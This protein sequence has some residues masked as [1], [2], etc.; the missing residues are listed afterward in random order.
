MGGDRHLNLGKGDQ[1]GKE[2]RGL[3]DGLFQ[4]AATFGMTAEQIK[5]YKLQLA[6]ATPEQLRWASA[7]AATITGQ[8]EGKALY[9]E[10][11]QAQKDIAGITDELGLKVS[12]ATGEWKKY[13]EIQNKLAG[14]SGLVDITKAQTMNLDLLQRSIQGSTW[15]IV[16]KQL[17]TWEAM[18]DLGSYTLTTFDKMS[19]GAHDLGKQMSSALTQMIV[20]G[21][22][23]TEVLAG[24]LREL[25]AYI[26]KAFVFKELS[27]F[28]QGQAGSGN[29]TWGSIS[30]F[31]GNFFGGLSGNALGG[32]V[33]GGVPI[34]VGEQGPEVFMPSVAG[35]IVPN[36]ALGGDIYNIDARGANPSVVPRLRQMLRE[37]H[38]SAVR[39]AVN[40]TRELGLRTGKRG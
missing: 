10:I 24:M 19:I 37:V 25:E 16:A 32:P 18:R 11:T 13:Y 7:L 31:L 28:F 38:D 23:W 9:A 6:S 1:A 22:D 17:K 40:A 30:N 14:M 27:T 39:T 2:I 15:T 20:Y 36:G 8:N 26:I 12:G 3:I 21:R 29:D 34:L 33:S 5:L 35:Q 4:E